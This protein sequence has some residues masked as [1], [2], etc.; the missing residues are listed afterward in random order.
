MLDYRELEATDQRYLD[1]FIVLVCLYWFHRSSDRQPVARRLANCLR[2][3][4]SA[5]LNRNSFD[6]LS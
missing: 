2:E 6:S 4:A 5:S 3:A 1:E